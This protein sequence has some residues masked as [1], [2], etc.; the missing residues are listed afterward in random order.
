MKTEP[1]RIVPK[2]PPRGEARSA[3]LDA[4]LGLVRRQGWAATSVDQLCEAAGV[5]KGAFFHHF[6]S[7]DALGVAAAERWTEVASRRFASADYHQHADPLERIQAYL[8]LRAAM[9][10]GPLEAFTCFAGTTVQEAF[11]TSEPVRAACGASIMGHASGL[12]ADFEEAIA[13][14][15]PRAA[16][17]AESLALFTQTVLQGAFVLAKAKGDRTPVIEAIAHLS[18][19]LRLIF[20]AHAPAP[21]QRSGSMQ[22]RSPP[23]RR[24]KS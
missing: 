21:G 20:G 3:I 13:T 5:S 18:S 10:S 7:K 11:A 22:R 16:V 2:P 23:A 17:T 1:R 6:A 24:K 19:Y 4:A 9:A 14:Y 8:A 12:E 15:P